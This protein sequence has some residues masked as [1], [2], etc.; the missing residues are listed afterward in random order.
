MLDKKYLRRDYVRYKI[1]EDIRYYSNKIP[2]R[3]DMINISKKGILMR[4]KQIF[5]VGDPVLVEIKE[6]AINWLQFKAIV[7]HIYNSQYV[8]L[9]FNINDFEKLDIYKYID[10][11]LSDKFS[12]IRSTIWEQ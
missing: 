2:I 11:K 7:K 3:A 10:N 4:V 5:C 9:E 6:D 12:K 1:T 8:G